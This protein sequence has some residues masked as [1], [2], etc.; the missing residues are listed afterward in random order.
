MN[1]Y[2]TNKLK[3]P[4]INNRPNWNYVKT[5]GCIIKSKT[6]TSQVDHTVL[7]EDMQELKSLF[8]NGITLW[9]NTSTFLDYSQDNRTFPTP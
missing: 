4:N 6:S 1:Y 7:Q 3:I 8:D 5:L 9:H 2:K